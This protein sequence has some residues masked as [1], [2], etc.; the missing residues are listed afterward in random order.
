MESIKPTP[1]RNFIINRTNRDFPIMLKNRLLSKEKLLTT[2][3]LVLKLEVAIIL[4]IIINILI[5]KMGLYNRFVKT[6]DPPIIKIGSI[7]IKTRKLIGM[8]IKYLILTV[9]FAI[10]V[11][12]I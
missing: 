7:K 2:V 4:T 9:M 3:K 8:L 6:I 12:L 10:I 1:L 11:F 5:S